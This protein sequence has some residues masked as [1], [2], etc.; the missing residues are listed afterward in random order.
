MVIAQK[1]KELSVLNLAE[2]GVASAHNADLTSRSTAEA[3]QFRRG[4]ISAFLERYESR[5]SGRI[6]RVRTRMEVRAAKMTEIEAT[7]DPELIAERQASKSNLISAYMGEWA[8]ELE[9]EHSEGALR[10]DLK[11]LT[12]IADTPSGP[13]VL[14][15]IGSGQNWVGYHV[16]AH[17]AL[18][19][20]FIEEDRPVPRFLFLD[21]PTQAHYPSDKQNSDSQQDSDRR[22]VRNLYRFLDTFTKK[23]RDFQIIVCDHAN[24]DEDWFQ[25]AVVENWREGEKLVPE[26]WSLPEA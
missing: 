14:R 2:A 16:V 12:V 10:L 23:Y 4:R 15:R 17:A 5:D 8:R 11:N 24:L 6:G 21:Q 9:L 7:I 25:K 19:R 26:D 13:A 20:I 1:T 18:H 22:A 3:I